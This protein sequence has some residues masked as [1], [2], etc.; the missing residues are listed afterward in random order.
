[1]TDRYKNTHT[2]SKG[3]C[4]DKLKDKNNSYIF[5]QNNDRKTPYICRHLY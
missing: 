1:M 5:L 4:K 3:Q 2:K